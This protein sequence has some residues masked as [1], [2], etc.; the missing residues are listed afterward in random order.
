MVVVGNGN[1]ISKSVSAH[2]AWFCHERSHM[3][4]TYMSPTKNTM[5]A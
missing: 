5:G 2:Y 4:L 1:P 3:V